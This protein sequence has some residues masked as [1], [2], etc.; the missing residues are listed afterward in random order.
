MFK[1]II[2]TI[3]FFIIG[4][5]FLFTFIDFYPEKFKKVENYIWANLITEKITFFN[6]DVKEFVRKMD[7]NIFY[8]H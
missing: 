4:L 3:L 2:I 7:Y 1:I 6:K 8:N 5:A